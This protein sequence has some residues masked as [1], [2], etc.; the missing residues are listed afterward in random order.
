MSRY[1]SS[2]SEE[3]PYLLKFIVNLEDGN[4]TVGSSKKIEWKCD[5]C[6]T[7]FL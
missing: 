7:H 1:L 6:G 4:L 5:G 2:I 3:R